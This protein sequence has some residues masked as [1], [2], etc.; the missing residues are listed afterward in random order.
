MATRFQQHRPLARVP[1]I[2]T[3]IRAMH[4]AFAHAP[5][6]ES[7][8]AYW[9]DH[10]RQHATPAES[11]FGRVADFKARVL[12]DFINR[13]DTESV[14][15]W[16]CGDAS[17]MILLECPHYT[18][19]DICL[20]V[21]TRCKREFKTDARKHF[22]LATEAKR[23]GVIA[24]LALSLDV[25]YHLVEDDVF[26]AHM[27]ALTESSTHFIGICSSDKDAPGR[28][29]HVRHRSFSAWIARHTPQWK[30]V[31]FVRNPYPYDKANADQTSWSDFHFF[32]R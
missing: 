13:R 26:E 27:R 4:R 22:M 8:A 15:D 17:P 10:Y 24:E 12:R 1:L 9:K 31:E 7:S 21:I 30:R 23:A 11:A 14:I 20:D 18:G 19:V 32:A 28:A 5:R 25:I 29:S 6:F 3:C 16:G 2:D